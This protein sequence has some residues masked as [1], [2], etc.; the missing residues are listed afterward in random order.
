[1]DIDKLVDERLTA[2]SDFQSRISTLSDEEKNTETAKRRKEILGE[3]LT[4]RDTIAKDQKG[5]AEKAEKDFED[6]KKNNPPKNNDANQKPEDDLSQTDM[7]FLSSNG[8]HPDDLEEVKKARKILTE[9]GKPLMPISDVLKDPT[10]AAILNSRVEKR[11]TAN[12]MNNGGGRGGP[13]A[14]SDAEV[15]EAASKGG[16]IPEK[17]SPEAEQLFKARAEKRRQNK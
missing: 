9:A 15:A 12:A 14:K 6:Y 11:K 16:V 2:D 3:E 8:V 13:T 5:R 4:K 1:M 17:G 7:Y 10:F